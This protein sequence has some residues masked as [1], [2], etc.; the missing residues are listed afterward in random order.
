MK[1][2]NMDV[3]EGN[4]AF[5][6]ENYKKI[7]PNNTLNIIKLSKDPRVESYM[8]GKITACEELGVGC[9]VHAPTDRAEL[10]L[11]LSILKKD[12]TQKIIIQ[13]PINEEVFGNIYE[14]SKLVDREQDVDGFE[15]PIIKFR[16]LRT[17]PQYLNDATFS[18][19]AKGVLAMMFAA[20]KEKDS[21]GWKK[22]DPMNL[23][24][25]TI[26]VIGTGLTSGLPIANACM[27]LGATV[28][29][30]C[31]STSL[32]DLT[33]MVGDSTIVV[34]CSGMPHIVDK[35]LHSVRDNAIY[36]NVG[37]NRVD[38]KML[39]DICQDDVLE[40]PNTLYANPTFKSTGRLTCLF[41]ALNTLL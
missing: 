31:S 5:L 2:L 24:G 28:Y 32:E 21:L 29:T 14:L 19:T 39:G 34:G 36:I 8:K 1:Y 22:I 33:A 30:A 12:K 13:T 6:V 41:C 40:L 3:L 27:S 15:F 9:Q 38:G 35:D 10:E 20:R 25:E 17:I 26:T 37:M 16:E 11:L 4:I 7:N 18:P 23:R